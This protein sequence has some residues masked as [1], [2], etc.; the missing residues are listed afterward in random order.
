MFDLFPGLDLA[1]CLVAWVAATYTSVAI[2]GQ[3]FYDLTQP[4]SAGN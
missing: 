2:G 4:L 1:L 3:T